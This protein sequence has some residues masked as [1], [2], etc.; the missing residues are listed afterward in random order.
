MKKG[1]ILVYYIKFIS[2][3]YVSSISIK[4]SK[5]GNKSLVNDN[6]TPKISSFL[7]LNMA[8]TEHSPPQILNKSQNDKIQP[9]AGGTNSP[10]INTNDINKL[11]FIE[12]AVSSNTI[13]ELKPNIKQ[14]TFI[15]KDNMKKLPMQN[16][17]ILPQQMTSNLLNYMNN[18][19]PYPQQR[20]PINNPTN[21]NNQIPQIPQ[22]INNSFRQNQ[23]I[24]NNNLNKVL[25]NRPPLEE[26]ISHPNN[27]EKEVKVKNEIKLKENDLSI[28]KEKS[29][30]IEN[31][32]NQEIKKYNTNI[33]EIPR[34][35]IFDSQ[36][37]P[38]ELDISNI[39][40]L[41]SII[42]ELSLT[43]QKKEQE[44][45]T[46]KDKS[47]KLESNYENLNTQLQIQQVK[48]DSSSEQVNTLNKIKSSFLS[49]IN[50]LKNSHDL[51]T[52]INSY[53]KNDLL[54]II[55]SKSSHLNSLIEEIKKKSKENKSQIKMME[56]ENKQNLENLQKLQNNNK[57]IFNKKDEI[58]KKIKEK[59]SSFELLNKDYVEQ[60]QE[61]NILL[62]Q[63]YEK[64][65]ENKIKQKEIELL[66]KE[67]LKEIERAEEI[68]KQIDKSKELNEFL[69][70]QLE[71]LNEQEKSTDINNK[72]QENKVENVKK[73]LQNSFN[74]INKKL[75]TDQDNFN[76]TVTHLS[77]YEKDLTNKI[78]SVSIQNNNLLN[79]SI[80]DNSPQNHSFQEIRFKQ[81]DNNKENK[82]NKE[83]EATFDKINVGDDESIKN[84]IISLLTNLN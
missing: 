60:I 56:N 2:F 6:N 84:Q 78:N 22:Q 20:A 1:T 9:E 80:N 35:T 69:L 40:Q 33:I 74:S 50:K 70:K 58:L 28:K 21:I 36:F 29:N 41:D 61:E 65:A 81:I 76:L 48:I 75:K 17:L 66:K 39:K 14:N 71:E 62:K 53:Y 46:L 31:H 52:N 73:E 26:Q 13:D 5:I 45:E 23:N 51:L 43:L 8:S 47:I 49:E 54:S 7:N 27:T 18:P 19:S 34:E 83:N 12:K 42:S 55:N 10:I 3:L 15:N 79:S 37:N 44:S 32:T 11:S 38:P 59:N 68:K 64:E 24:I 4:F 30:D 72:G 63:K 25:P 57:E 77:N 67:N 16:N 82:E